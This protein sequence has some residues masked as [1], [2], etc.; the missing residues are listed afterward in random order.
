MQLADEQVQVQLKAPTAVESCSWAGRPK[1]EVRSLLDFDSW[2]LANPG[3]TWLAGT[4][5]AP[6][7]LE[8]E[9]GGWQKTMQIVR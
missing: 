2:Q 1:V 8:F 5:S 7:L 4:D 9:H 3:S 6:H